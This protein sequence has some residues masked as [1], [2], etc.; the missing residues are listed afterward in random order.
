M[1]GQISSAVQWYNWV[2][3]LS[4]KCEDDAIS[5]Y[6]AEN[7]WLYLFHELSSYHITSRNKKGKFYVMRVYFAFFWHAIS[8]RQGNSLWST[9]DLAFILMH[10]K[11][12]VKASRKVELIEGIKNHVWSNSKTFSLFYF[13]LLI[14]LNPNYFFQSGL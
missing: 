14:F 13:I 7:V 1:Q 5:S 8:F 3:G 4:N 2:A 10:L 12:N 6:L 11:W 9:L